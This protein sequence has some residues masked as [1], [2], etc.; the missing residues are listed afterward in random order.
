MT[1]FSASCRKASPFA[2]PYAIFILIDHGRGSNTPATTEDMHISFSKTKKK[3]KKVKNYS[4][5]LTIKF[6]NILDMLE[7]LPTTST[8]RCPQ[9]FV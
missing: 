5:L 1:G 4:W 9:H 6:C 3:A 8:F 2:A 7:E